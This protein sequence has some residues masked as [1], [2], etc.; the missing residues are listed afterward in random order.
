VHLI[1]PVLCRSGLRLPELSRL[2]FVSVDPFVVTAF[3]V[4]SLVLGVV[5]ADEDGE[6]MRILLSLDILDVKMFE[7]Q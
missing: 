6:V 5:I 1:A 7:N 3:A 2:V 4:L